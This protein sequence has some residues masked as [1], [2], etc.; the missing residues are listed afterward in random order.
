MI[1]Q[2]TECLT[3][4]KLADDKMKPA[5]VRV[6][7]TSCDAVFTAHPP[8]AA[9][10]P[11]PDPSP[12]PQP[13]I[14]DPADFSDLSS[15][16]EQS[17][18]A[19]VPAPDDNPEEDFDFGEFN[20]EG[21]D[22][23]E[24]ESYEL[25]PDQASPP[26]TSAQAMDEQS[27]AV[28]FPEF[29]L[30]EE[31]PDMGD[32]ESDAGNLPPLE[33]FNLDED[34]SGFDADRP[35]TEGHATEQLSLSEEPDTGDEFEVTF[36]DL[37]HDAETPEFDHNSLGTQEF[38]FDEAAD[39]PLIDIT[40]SEFSGPVEF[41]F[42]GDED[43]FALPSVTPRVEN[44]PQS[45]DEFIFDEETTLAPVQPQVSPKPAPQES[46]PQSEPARAEKPRM[47]TQKAPPK[48]KSTKRRTK[49]SG[50][51]GVLIFLLFLLLAGAGYG[52]FGWR[53]DTYDPA[54]LIE[55]AQLLIS[56]IKSNEQI[57]PIDIKDLRSQFVS[58]Q[59][60]G[61]LFVIHGNAV[62]NHNGAIS[63]IS[64]R[65]I[66]YDAAGKA[67]L[68]Q[69]AF[70]GNSLDEAALRTLP[71]SKIEETMNNQ[72]GDALSN[73]NIDPE[74]SIPFTVVFRNIPEHVSE[75]TVEVADSRPGA[76]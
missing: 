43:P 56:G 53:Q 28:D 60:A 31:L 46:T 64:V 71:Y 72:F 66:I 22:E 15:D 17:G 40:R 51:R 47:A 8:V 26:E 23:P 38:S 62:N 29:D 61:T 45:N 14:T 57:R 11:A 67:I 13:K 25:D 19:A 5:G 1:I 7:C 24:S 39:E 54:I 73:L 55:R 32:S 48:L 16:V 59:V 4:F 36:E 44:E 37:S 9:A 74:Q 10:I 21:F 6:R 35:T 49:R 12:I 3:R 34:F 58:N 42:D 76:R 27:T 68:Q 18:A 33:E 75:F 2:C 52:Y 20:M 69:T 41:S 50:Y 65:G 63:T 30:D 70:C